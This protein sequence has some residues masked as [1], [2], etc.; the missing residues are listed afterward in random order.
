MMNYKLLSLSILLLSLKP[1]HAMEGE[2]EIPKVEEEKY[3]NPEPLLL[4]VKK[5]I[6]KH[7]AQRLIEEDTNLV[8]QEINAL[9]TYPVLEQEI[10]NSI[11]KELWDKYA[12]TLL[13]KSSPLVYDLCGHSHP[14]EGIT[15]IAFSPDSQYIVTGA[16]NGTLLLRNVTDINTI[17][18]LQGHTKSITA[19]AFSPNSNYILTGSADK[20]ALLWDITD[21]NNITSYPLVGHTRYISSIAFGPDNKYVL[22]GSYDTKAILWSITDLNNIESYK[23]EGHEGDISAVALSSDGK[24]ALT[25]SFD[26]TARVW[27]I[28]DVNNIKSYPLIGHK[29]WITS[30]V[31][32]LDS[33]YA[34]TG[35]R[36][37]TAI[38]WNLT[39]LPN[40][41][42][43]LLKG[44]TS[45][46]NAVGFS[47]DSK[48]AL[49]GSWDK[50]AKLWDLESFGQFRGG[51]ACALIGHIG[52][53]QSIGFSS[54]GKYALTGSWDAQARL[55]DL[56]NL[57]NLQYSMF[58]T[59]IPE[60]TILRGHTGTVMALFSPDSR[61]ILTCSNENNDA[62]L[63][64]LTDNGL[65]FNQ[66]IACIKEKENER[67]EA[68]KNKGSYCLIQ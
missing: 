58:K 40:T 43:I 17:I 44:H 12:F 52:C 62:R 50:T 7:M 51:W 15:V 31:F 19:V 56:T 41:T 47:P 63:W 6:T 68:E 49:T 9:E 20:T 39:N 64:D 55:W 53:I 26:H 22:T 25:G 23:L 65:D 27:G 36:D 2:K 33:K 59:L 14:A 3:Y 66:I 18:P 10:K 35:S 4:L 30:A 8:M 45:G 60:Y 1:S 61:Y 13:K 42:N 34:L 5:V 54:N 38:L 46:V 16:D 67:I 24:Y 21:L 11:K 48:Y 29:G 37:N 57:K 32:S 28:A